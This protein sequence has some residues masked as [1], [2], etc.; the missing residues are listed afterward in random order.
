VYVA[1]QCAEMCKRSR[2]RWRYN[3]TPKGQTTRDPN[4]QSA[5]LSKTA[6]DAI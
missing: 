6:G 1:Q 5:I 3:L 2:D 4:A